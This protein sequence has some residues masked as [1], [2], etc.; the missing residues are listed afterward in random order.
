MALSKF[1][2]KKEAI[3]NKK[4]ENVFVH[5]VYFWLHNPTQPEDQKKFLEGLELLKKCKTI[6]SYHVGKP[7]GTSRSVIDASYTYSWLTIFKNADDE[8]A[9]QIDPIHIQ[10]VKE[11][12]H[13]WSKVIVYDSIDV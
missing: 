4:I 9:Y 6:Q 8:Q 1:N 7:A 11:Y 13:L 2:T 12:Q 3:K 5:Q 10:F